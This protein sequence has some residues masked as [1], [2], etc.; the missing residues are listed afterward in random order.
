MFCLFFKE[1]YQSI[2]EA[3]FINLLENG[4]CDLEDISKTIFLQCVFNLKVHKIEN[5]LGSDFE[6]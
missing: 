5:F 6:F 2:F 4:E 1:I 3:I